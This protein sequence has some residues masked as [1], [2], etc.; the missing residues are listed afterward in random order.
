[1]LKSWANKEKDCTK[2]VKTR[3]QF[4]EEILELAC[5][6]KYEC[7]MGTTR[8]ILTSSRLHIYFLRFGGDKP[9]FLNLFFFRTSHTF[10]YCLMRFGQV[11][12]YEWNQWF[13]RDYITKLWAGWCFSMEPVVL[14]LQSVAE[15]VGLFPGT[16]T[17]DPH[18]RGSKR[19]V[20]SLF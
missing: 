20:S 19:S 17:C 5:C 13:S 11:D 3:Q 10:F 4:G 14:K 1:M 8:R 16:R 12:V 2:F 9:L 15:I 7:L 18:I 6:T